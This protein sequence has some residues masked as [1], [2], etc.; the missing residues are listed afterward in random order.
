MSDRDR[1]VLD[2]AIEVL[3]TR[4][5]RQLTHRAVDAAAELP[6][7]STSN[8]FRTRDALLVGVLRRALE[9]ETDL[10]T[11]LAADIGPPDVS[12]VADAIGRL[13]EELVADGRVLSQ[14]RRTIFVEATN[15]PALQ[16]EIG[17]LRDEI[18]GWLA[19]L[20]AELGSPEPVRD[21]D[22]LLALMDGLV[23]NQLTSPRPCFDPTPAIA[24]L[25]VGLVAAPGAPD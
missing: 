7:G 16:A 23:I 22:H 19:P 12:S 17:L 9:R 6:L 10:W 11:K 13:L 25:L 2:A 4:S 8:R 5:M 15:Q 1:Q 18:S 24:A 21:V 14:A 3:G 20:L